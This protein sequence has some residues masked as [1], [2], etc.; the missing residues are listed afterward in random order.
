MPPLGCSKLS[1]PYPKER[2]GASCTPRCLCCFFCRE[3]VPVLRHLLL[4]PSPFLNREQTKLEEN[5][6]SELFFPD[7]FTWLV[8]P[9]FFFSFF[10]ATVSAG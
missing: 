4:S 9:F 2:S 6:A 7:P 5:L 3:S 8:F 1:L 10:P